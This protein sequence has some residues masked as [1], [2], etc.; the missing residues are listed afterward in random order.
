MFYSD[1]HEPVHVHVI[2]GGCEAKYNVKPLQQ[3]YNH[4]FKKQEISMIE[5]LVKE[6]AE[7]IEERWNQFFKQ[8]GGEQR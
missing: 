3:V 6:N 2:K 5:D 8:K 4:G 1:D 7:V